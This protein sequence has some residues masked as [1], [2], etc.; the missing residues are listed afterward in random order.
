MKLSMNENRL[1]KHR[2]GAIVVLVALLLPMTIILAGF[3]INLAYMELN[4]TELYIATDAAARASGREFALTGDAVSAKNKARDAA[5]RNK[6]AGNALQLADSDIIFGE[7]IR[8]SIADK[9]NFNAAGANPNAVKILGRRDNGSLN[10]PIGLLMPNIFSINS[11][12]AVQEARSTLVEVDIALVIDRSGSMAYS[13]SE[14]AV[15][16][17]I[18]SSAPAGW[19]F[20]QPVPP[21]S[22]WLD[23]VAATDSFLGELAQSPATELVAL[24]TYNQT[25][26]TDRT[27][28]YDYPAVLSATTPY[29]LSFQSGH[30]NIAAGI[31]AGVTALSSGLSRPWAIKAIV[32]LTDGIQ[33]APGDPASAAEAAVAQ[34]IMIFTVT[35]AAEADQSTMQQVAEIGMG[36]H[37]HA[38]SSTDLTLVFSNIAKSLP[39]LLTK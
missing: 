17:P 32:L 7:S 19:Q 3:A 31:N 39:T 12:Q 6:V 5:G 1:A 15:Y 27:L 20:G 2:T 14:P 30:T 35:F 29:S 33:T 37:F 8:A 25:S 28:S 36:R 22:R 34:G 13:A 38:T 23:A 21:N 10:G 9:Y 16:P 26:T 18:P 24:C 4:R 11:F